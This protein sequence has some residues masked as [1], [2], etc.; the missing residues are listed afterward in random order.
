M[1]RPSEPPGLV[2]KEQIKHHLRKRHGDHNEI[3]PP[4]FAP[5][6][7]Y[8]QA[9][10]MQNQSTTNWQRPPELTASFWGVKN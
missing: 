4:A 10:P 9:L 8:D 7:T 1:Y 3:D 2:V 5:Q 6:K